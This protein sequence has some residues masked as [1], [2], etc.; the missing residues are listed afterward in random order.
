VAG[1][2]RK[3]RRNRCVN[4]ALAAGEN[5]PAAESQRDP[6]MLGIVLADTAR[7]REEHPVDHCSSLFA[8][9]PGADYRVA[10]QRA[11]TGPVATRPRRLSGAIMV[12]GAVEKTR[13]ST[14]FRPQRP[15]RCA[16]TSSSTTAL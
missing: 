1:R 11:T 5:H 10:T 13:T 14:G 4:H 15:Q 3:Q 12:I 2:R 7:M 6:R 9:L 16:T 8:M